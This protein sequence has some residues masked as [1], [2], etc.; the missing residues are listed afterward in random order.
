MMARTRDNPSVRLLRKAGLVWLGLTVLLAATIV[1]AYLPL[2]SWKPLVGLG[3]SVAKTALVVLIFMELMSATAIVRFAAAAGVAFLLVL[4]AL[5]FADETTRQHAPNL[6]PTTAV[7]S[8][9]G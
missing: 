7:P 1:G 8:Q 5:T 4:F 6:F 9:D 2:G 3:I